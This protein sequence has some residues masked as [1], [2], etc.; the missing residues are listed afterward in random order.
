M[1]N[2]LYLSNFNGLEKEKVN[3]IFSKLGM[4]KNVRAE[5]LEIE[6]YINIADTISVM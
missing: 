2:S 3:D 4:D 1:I 5:E 6:D